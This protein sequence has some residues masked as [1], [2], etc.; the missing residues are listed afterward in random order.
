MRICAGGAT[1]RLRE[2]REAC[3][4]RLFVL[5]HHPRFFRELRRQLLDA[6]A[7][8]RER[9]PR[10]TRHV[11][12]RDLPR[13]RIGR[14]HAEHRIV[15]RPRQ[16]EVQLRDALAEHV[17]GFEIAAD[18]VA[19]FGGDA[20]AFA[21]R[22]PVSGGAAARVVAGAGAGQRRVEIAGGRQG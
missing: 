13:P 22:A 16:R 21:A 20:A 8:D 6:R 14:L 12:G 7:E 10:L 2:P 17:G 15:F 19:R 3:D 4:Q 11:L 9:Q 1:G 18:G 5:H